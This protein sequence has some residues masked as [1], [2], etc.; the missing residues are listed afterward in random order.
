MAADRDRSS[1]MSV[2][3][4]L[5]RLYRRLAEVG[6][7]IPAQDFSGQFGAADHLKTIKREIVQFMDLYGGEVNDATMWNLRL[8][9]AQVDDLLALVSDEPRAHA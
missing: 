9:A 6:A 4:R 1:S 2:I 3:E 7:I 5:S 8:A